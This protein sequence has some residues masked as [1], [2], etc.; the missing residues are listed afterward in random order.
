MKRSFTVYNEDNRGIWGR[1]TITAA[2]EAGRVLTYSAFKVWL[3][4]MQDKHGR[5][6][7]REI[8]PDVFKELVRAGYVYKNASQD[9]WIFDVLRSHGNSDD[10]QIPESWRAV[11]EIYNAT[12][13]DYFHV[14][15]KLD[16]AGIADHDDFFRYW[17]DNIDSVMKLENR[18]EP[19]YPTSWDCGV[20][21]KWWN[22]SHDAHSRSNS[23]PIGRQSHVAVSNPTP[24]HKKETTAKP[25]SKERF[26]YA[27]GP[28]LMYE[29]DGEAYQVL[30][31]NG[32]AYYFNW[33]NSQEYDTGFIYDEVAV[34][35]NNTA[36]R[37]QPQ[38]NYE[39]PPT[40]TEL[41]DTDGEIPF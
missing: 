15:D 14:L 6:Q 33:H 40:F 13:D 41:S 35:T 10:E 27:P 20:L 9:G 5:P 29:I 2:E 16:Q 8:N 18:G 21:V 12:D 19:H 31:K 4:F 25:S 30:D 23:S 1:I 37:A 28:G 34:I 36:Q 7:D 26:Y 17:Q 32:E 11:A 24:V 38:N 39:E 22:S 3:R